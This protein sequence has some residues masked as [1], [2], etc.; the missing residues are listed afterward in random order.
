MKTPAHKDEISSNDSDFRHHLY[1]TVI[2]LGGEKKIASLLKK[3]EDYAL[4]EADID[5]LRR[6]NISLIERTKNI[7]ANTNKLVIRT[8]QQC[9]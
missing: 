5:E 2:L 9:A 8:S 6:Y 7:L 3:L 4:T 1:D